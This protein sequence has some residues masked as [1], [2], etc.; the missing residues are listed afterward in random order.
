MRL[1][2]TLSKNLAGKRRKG[3]S[4]AL[5]RLRIKEVYILSILIGSG[6]IARRQEA[7]EDIRARG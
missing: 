4:E 5:Q 1:Q 6:D 7:L 3:G 2:I